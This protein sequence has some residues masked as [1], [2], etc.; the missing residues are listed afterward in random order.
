MVL[1]QKRMEFLVLVR[2]ELLP[3]VEVKDLRVLF[4]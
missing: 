2:D 4:E 1:R 3:Q